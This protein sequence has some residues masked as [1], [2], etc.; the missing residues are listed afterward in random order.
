MNHWGD[1]P[2]VTLA[3]DMYQ[4]LEG[5]DALVILTEWKMFWSPDFNKMKQLMRKPVIFDG[6][7]IFEP[8]LL[9]DKG[10]RYFAVGRGEIV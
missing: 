8:D 1:K 10:F 9:E 2:G 4:V 7:N 5:I 6:R 3:N